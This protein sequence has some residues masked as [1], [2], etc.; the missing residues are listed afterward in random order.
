MKIIIHMEVTS[1][2]KPVCNACIIKSEQMSEL[3]LY[4]LLQTQITS[5]ISP[6]STHE[7]STL[8]LHA[9]H[10]C[11]LHPLTSLL[12]PQP[13]PAHKIFTKLT[14]PSKFSSR[15]C[16]DFM[17][18]S[19][20]SLLQPAKLNAVRERQESHLSLTSVD[21]DD[22]RSNDVTLDLF[23]VTCSSSRHDDRSGD[24]SAESLLSKRLK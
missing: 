19:D 3:S 14:H 9:M 10:F 24:R 12:L 20:S 4:I 1:E 13:D 11:N 15:N 22:E 16:R 21:A 7:S 17:N 6:H 2:S 18:D 8:F 5:Q 23:T